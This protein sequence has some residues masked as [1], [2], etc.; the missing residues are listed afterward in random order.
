[1]PGSSGSLAQVPIPF[2]QGQ[3]NPS[4]R[5]PIPGSGSSLGQQGQ[6]PHGHAQ[7][8]ALACDD[9]VTLAR[10]AQERGL[11]PLPVP[12]NYYDD[13]LARFDL[14]SEQVATL[15]D[16]QLLYDRDA[17]GEYVHFYTPTVGGVFFEV[18]ERRGSYDGYGAGNA[19]VR[20]AAQAARTV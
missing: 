14:A 1:M 16:L 9:V 17:G 3:Q 12:G 13:L 11:R 2:G 19:P 15:R 7:H 5:F 8:I 20:L 10:E 18:V 6:P 4:G